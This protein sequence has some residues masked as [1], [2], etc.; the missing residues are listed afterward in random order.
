MGRNLNLHEGDVLEY[1]VYDQKETLLSVLR[2]SKFT[3]VLRTFCKRF[4]DQILAGLCIRFRIKNLSNGFC[5]LNIRSYIA[6][7]SS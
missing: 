5:P 6:S 2:S 4:C 3:A 7:K 1:I